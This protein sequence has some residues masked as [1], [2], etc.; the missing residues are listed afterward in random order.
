MP[1]SRPGYMKYV[2]AATKTTVHGDPCV[3]TNFVG[4]AV[5]QRKPSSSAA[6]GVAGQK[7]IA[8]GEPFAIIAKGIVQVP[9]T[10]SGVAAANVGDPIYII[11]ASNLLT[12]TSTSNVKYGRLN[13]KAGSRGTPT[14]KCRIDLDDK[15]SF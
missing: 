9:N 13:E 3:E 12:T 14:G 10:G 2:A 11:A 4:V 7:T 8:I 5:K 1:Y 6:A 15:D